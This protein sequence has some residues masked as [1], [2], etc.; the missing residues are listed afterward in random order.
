MRFLELPAD[1]RMVTEAEGMTVQVTALG[2]ARLWMEERS[3]ERIIVRGDRDVEFDYFVNG[4]RLGFGDRTPVVENE[5][6]IPRHRDEP[7][8]PQLPES[9]RQLMVDSGILNP[10][11]TPNEAT[12]AR[13]GWTLVDRP[14]DDP[15]PAQRSER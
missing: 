10:D 8:L 4:L 5:Y 3:L 15:E 9:V 7:F 6:F 2:D 14:D 11:Y 12:A 13:L 1:F